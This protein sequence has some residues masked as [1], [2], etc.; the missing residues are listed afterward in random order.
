MKRYSELYGDIE[1]M[2]EMTIPLERVVT[3]ERTTP[4]N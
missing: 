1:R 3:R 2:A 4:Q